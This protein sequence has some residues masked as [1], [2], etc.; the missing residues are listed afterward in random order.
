MEEAEDSPGEQEVVSSKALFAGL[1]D[2]SISQDIPIEG[3]I[4]IPTSTHAQ[5]HDSSTLN[6]S[7]HRTI[8]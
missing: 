1:S 6:E 3:E 7:I 4:T 5:E 2:V 8:M